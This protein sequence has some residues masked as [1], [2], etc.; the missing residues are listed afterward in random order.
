MLSNLTFLKGNLQLAGNFSVNKGI[1]DYS[2]RNI[3]KFLLNKLEILEKVKQLNGKGSD[4][5]QK[6]SKILK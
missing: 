4:N 3:F 1:I 5:S 2:W 6:K